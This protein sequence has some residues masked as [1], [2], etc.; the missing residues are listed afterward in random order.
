MPELIFLI[1]WIFLQFFWNFLA[2]VGYELNSGLKFFSLFL[3]LS[4][5]VLAKNNA[6]KRFLNFLNLFAIFFKIFFPRPS[7]N[8][9][10]EKKNFFSLFRPIYSLLAKSNSEKRFSNFL[11]F[12]TIFIGIF[13]L[14]LGTN[15]IQDS[16]FFFSFSAYLIP[17]WLKIMPERGFLIFCIFL[18]FFSEFSSP[19]RVWMEIGAKFFSS[20]FFG[21]STPVLAKNKSGKRFFNFL[22]FFSIFFETFLPGPS[23]NGIAD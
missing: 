15:K 11:I 13:L 5:P 18:L 23:M 17:F 3:G 6:G 8:E 12:Y 19:G 21:L 14:W 22:I 4:H 10:R 1:F 2:W 9:N 16:N 20:L 7:R